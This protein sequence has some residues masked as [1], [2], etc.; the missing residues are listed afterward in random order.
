MELGIWLWHLNE[1]AGS[2]AGRP[3]LRAALFPQCGDELK[4]LVGLFPGASASFVCP[5]CSPSVWPGCCL[6]AGPH[7]LPSPSLG[8]PRGPPLEQ[9]R[10]PSGATRVRS[11][12]CICLE[13]PLPPSQAQM[14]PWP[15]PLQGTSKGALWTG[16]WVTEDRDGRRTARPSRPPPCSPQALVSSARVVL[17]FRRNQAGLEAQ[18]CLD[19]RELYAK[20]IL[21]AGLAPFGAQHIQCVQVAFFKEILFFLIIFS[22]WLWI[23]Y[24]PALLKYGHMSCRM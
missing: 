6:P 2:Q 4:P 8:L 9:C 16:M 14:G 13:S 5:F 17:S 10:T 12:L 18:I 20:L 3:A 19:L 7:L 23:F 24:F 11:L 15:S 22:W 1:E 21:S